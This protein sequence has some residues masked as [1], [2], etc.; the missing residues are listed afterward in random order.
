MQGQLVAIESIT[1]VADTDYRAINYKHCP[2]KI[3]NEKS[4]SSTSKSVIV[5][6]YQMRHT[7]ILLVQNYFPNM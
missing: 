5:I 7:L 6:K 1:E 3:D 2:K 4:S